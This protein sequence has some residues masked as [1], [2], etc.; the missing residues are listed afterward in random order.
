MVTNSSESKEYF[1]MQFSQSA[2]AGIPFNPVSSLP[3]SSQNINRL[4]NSMISFGWDDPRFVSLEQANACGWSVDAEAIGITVIERDPVTGTTHEILFANA[5]QVEGMPTLSAMLAMSEDELEN[6][7]QLA[8]GN[9]IEE[10]FIIAPAPKL[11]EESQTTKAQVPSIDES[12]G[13]DVLARRWDKN[14]QVSNAPGYLAINESYLG[15]A[16][17]PN[18]QLD[19]LDAE[20]IVAQD[21][22]ALHSIEN[23]D[24]RHFAALTMAHNAGS[25]IPYRNAL[26]AQSPKVFAELLAAMEENMERLNQKKVSATKLSKDQAVGQGK[27]EA[28]E[29]LAGSFRFAVMAPYMRNGLHNH[30]GLA[31][32][33]NI[34][35]II[36]EKKLH[37]DKEAIDRVMAVYNKARQLGLEVVPE[38]VYL[39]NQDLKLNI[40]QPAFLLNGTFARDKKGAYR[41]SIGGSP[42][43]IDQGDS[44]QLKSKTSET[45]KAAMEL[46]Q[47]KGWT[48]IELKGK[49]AMLADA[50]LEAAL[51]QPPLKVVNYS[52][53][54][55]D[56]ERF[57]ERLAIE[58]KRKEKEAAAAQNKAPGKSQSIEQLPQFMEIHNVV[59]DDG[60]TKTATMTYTV[61]YPGKEQVFG[62]AKDAAKAFAAID[63]ALDPVVV[64]TVTRMD[65]AVNEGIVATAGMKPTVAGK[66]SLSRIS[67]PEF[68]TAM[69]GVL[70]A[71]KAAEAAK[72]EQ[73]EPGVKVVSTKSHSGPIVDIKGDLVAQKTGRGNAVV[74]H[75]IKN[76]DGWLP[77]LGDAPDIS[78]AK[79]RGRVK[80]QQLG[81]EG[82]RER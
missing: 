21:I 22:A 81:I 6:M 54:P 39:D 25:Q 37:E 47:S 67:D 78:Y 53:T 74:W 32:A 55:K 64:K 13:R 59:G 38:Q 65:G 42:V 50:W 15:L 70:N 73:S 69:E 36:R 76:F 48:A 31:I 82:G 60:L 5:K 56:I 26:V 3:I 77:K 7:R 12:V 14:E 52:P 18:N 23:T 33:E 72:S 49:P 46:A 11:I 61:S 63:A 20:I 30:E 10:S 34:N 17:V 57:N 40:S 28:A 24:V 2:R 44:L 80:E 8:S 68:D 79:G 27:D 41:P 19:P 45:Y 29:A 62:T 4:K 35:K 71:Q 66:E 9:D 16:A 75:D 58:T 43:L 1:S 51:M